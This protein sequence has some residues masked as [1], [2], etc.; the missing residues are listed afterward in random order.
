MFRVGGQRQRYDNGGLVRNGSNQE[1][2][3]K[4]ESVVER[5]SEI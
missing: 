5:E 1:D 3:R 2:G 4:G